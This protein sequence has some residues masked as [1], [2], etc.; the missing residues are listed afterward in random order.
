M[1]RRLAEVSV[2]V[3]PE[4]GTKVVRRAVT[5]VGG[6]FAWGTLPKGRYRLAVRH[7]ALVGFEVEMRIVV[8]GGRGIEV[9]LRNDPAQPCGGATVRV[10]T[11]SVNGKRAGPLED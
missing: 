5:G 2:E 8:A 9:V 1:R 3:L 4:R 11:R 6:E 7:S 10:V